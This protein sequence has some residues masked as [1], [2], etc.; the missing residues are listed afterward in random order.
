MKPYKPK[1]RSKNARKRGRSARPSEELKIAV[2][3]KRPSDGLG[4]TKSLA[5]LTAASV[6]SFAPDPY[7]MDRA[8]AELHRRGFV[9][10]LKGRYTASVR[11]T[12]AQ[13][14]KAFG[15]K[16]SV[17]QLD[18]GK[19]YQCHKFYYPADGAPWNPDATLMSL[20]DD[21]YIQWPHLNF[22]AR[23]M[24]GTPGAGAI[25]A[26]PPYV[27]Y[28]HLEVP[29]DVAKLIGATAVH[30]AG[31]TGAGVRV[32]MID[33]GFDHSHP[34][35][36]AHGYTSSVVLAPG[37]T[38]RSTDPHSHGTGESANIF[39]IAPGAT[40]IGVKLGDDRNPAGGASILEGFL[41]ALK[42]K[43]HVI[44]ISM[45]F[46]LRD[47]GTDNPMRELPGSLKGL[48]TEIQGA[49]AS[50]IVV[51]FSAGNGHYAFPGQMPNVISAGGVFV[52]QDGGMRVSDY[53]T[54]FKSEIYPGR[55]VPDFSGL[56]GLLPNADYIMLPVPPKQEIDVDNS[57]H[58]RTARDDGWGVQ[59]HLRRRAAA[60]GRMRPSAPEEPGPQAFRHQSH[61]EA[62]G[63]RGSDG[64]CQ[65]RLGSL[66]HGLER[67]GGRCGNGA[68]RRVRGMAAGLSDAVPARSP[69]RL[70]P[71]S[72]NR[73]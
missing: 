18:P 11:G 4:P 52:D 61:L 14:E 30:Q 34:F 32:C 70:A 66:R 24:A 15:T 40:F 17:F 64:Q 19:P 51:V 12:R 8:L 42:H 7:D 48:E 16:L 2:T 29:G 53:A 72:E 38:N 6:G 5:R 54:A 67:C 50:G 63:A 44:S 46:D 1:S 28:W 60:R 23:T 9:T 45:G 10:S 68:R 41:E 73:P 71:F 3:F 36:T 27:P 39:A 31:T 33:T 21:A 47:D 37:A 56:V 20:I 69:A 55:S 59:R 62:N 65:P 22:G 49:I 57:A 13:F 35:F 43:P 26:R 58:D 25:S